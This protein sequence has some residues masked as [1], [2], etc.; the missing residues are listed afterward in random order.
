MNGRLFLAYAF[1]F[2]LCLSVTQAADP[3]KK[4]GALSFEKD[5]RKILKVHCLHCH[6]EVGVK[7]GNLDL[8]LMRFMVKGGDSGPA[9]VP[10]KSY[11]SE[12]ISRVVAH[13]M[14][15]V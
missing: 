13:E 8:R 4:T 6:G 11:Q 9:I 14:P 5:V 12:L 3:A 10:G 15:P 2:S 7:E 1:S